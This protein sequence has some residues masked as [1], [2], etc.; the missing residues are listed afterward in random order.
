MTFVSQ[1]YFNNFL[2]KLAGPRERAVKEACRGE[3]TEAYF[4]K[5]LKFIKIGQNAPH[6]ISQ[7]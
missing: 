2:L 7:S 6:T 1:I 5:K 4:K 3:R